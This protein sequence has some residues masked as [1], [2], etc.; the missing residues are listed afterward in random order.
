MDEELP[1]AFR[2]CGI[3][4]DTAQDMRSLM[5]ELIM[6]CETCAEA[7]KIIARRYSGP[8]NHR[9]CVFAG[10]AYAVLMNQAQENKVTE[11]D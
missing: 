2:D 10:Y 1:T 4:L 9:V 8:D 6:N 5:I 7:F 11:M 3:D